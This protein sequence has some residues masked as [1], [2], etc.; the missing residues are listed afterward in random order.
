MSDLGTL[1]GAFAQANAINDNGVVTGWSQ[2][3]TANLMAQTHAF[4]YKLWAPGPTSPIPPMVDLG[5]L[6]GFNSY[7]TCINESNHVVGY[8]DI[9]K[10]NNLFHAF[11]HNG[12]K[13]LDLGSL[14]GNT[15]KGDYS[16]A[17]GMNSADQVV[18][19]TFVPTYPASEHPVQV[20]QVAFIWTNVNKMIDLNTLTGRL[21]SRYYLF[22]AVAI[23]NNG[24]IAASAYVQ[25]DN[26]VH[27]VLLIPI[28]TQYPPPAP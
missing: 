9:S 27:T 2:T 1:G 11:F 6:G 24:Q 8:S 19:Y 17:L 21:G 4:V 10:T 25:G 14:A 5:T 16:M 22:S 18:G 28:K 13:M 7:G 20:K 23:N 12:E 26:S 3:A 15:P